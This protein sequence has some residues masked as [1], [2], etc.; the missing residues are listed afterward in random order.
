MI[1]SILKEGIILKGILFLSNYIEMLGSEQLKPLIIL[2]KIFSFIDFRKY[3]LIIYTHYF[4]DP[5]EDL[6]SI[7]EMRRHKFDS[8]FRIITSEIEGFSEIK[9]YKEIKKKYFNSFWPIKREKQ[10]YINREVRK[11]LEKELEE[12]VNTNFSEYSKIEFINTYDYKQIEND[13]TYLFDLE[14]VLFQ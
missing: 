13:K 5:C 12:L 14:I 3:V 1:I 2:N 4:E 9:D 8:D 10:K 6:D 11:E 7:E